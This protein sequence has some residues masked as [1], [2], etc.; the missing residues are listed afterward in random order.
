MQAFGYEVTTGAFW[1]FKLWAAG[2]P[3]RRAAGPPGRPAGAA[4]AA[5]DCFPKVS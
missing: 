3:G 1:I 2:P 5:T 4:P